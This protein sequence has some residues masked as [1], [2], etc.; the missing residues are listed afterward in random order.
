MGVFRAISNVLRSDRPA[1]V[2]M[3]VFAVIYALI[4][5]VNH[6]FFKTFALD[7]GVYTN[8]LYDYG[9]LHWNDKG[10]FKPVAENLLSDHLDFYLM[11]LAP[12]GF[13]F[14]QYTLQL[15]QIVFILFGSYGMYK[16]VQYKTD[17]T[18]MAFW[19][20]LS[21]LLSFAVFASLSFDYH[22]N[23]LAC[24]F[25]P[26]LFLAAEKN[27]LKTFVAL[28]IVI[29]LAKESMPLLMFFVCLGMGIELR[30]NK[31]IRNIA[32]VMAG[33]CLLYF[34][35][36]MKVIMPALANS[37]SYEHFKYHVLGNGYGDIPKFV[38]TRP[39][40]FLKALFINHSGKA[41]FDFIKAETYAFLL[42]S[43]AWLMIW[44]PAFLI[45]T[46][47]LLVMKMCYDDPAIW[48]IDTHYS[49]EFAPLIVTGA[50]YVLADMKGELLKQILAVFVVVGSLTATL[51]YMDN[52][53]YWHD[54]SRVR[55]YQASHY[56]KNYDVRVVHRQLEAIP[57]D[58]VVSAQ[59]PFVPHL[60]YRDKC[61]TFPI[62]K[63]AEYI[64]VSPS[65]EAMYPII[66]E[67]MD[68][69]IGDSLRTGR[70]GVQWRDT[71]VVVLRN[72]SGH[73]KPEK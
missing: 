28:V 26:W 24:M 25:L 6:Y 2:L 50:F 18:L 53:V 52:T 54:Y 67:E 59:T 23:V 11:A 12:L 60:A 10:V 64:I 41:E 57:A 15:F 47:P 37:G 36:A 31:R 39:L 72:L 49:I 27:R 30:Q 56:V 62:V 20:Q 16:L 63:D 8:T 22:S 55:I 51:R 1:F 5:F 48:S 7:L 65:E 73:R 66:R 61:Y 19:A 38:L 46:L 44:R 32:F 70:W 13:V 40:E 71:N 68:K 29:C 14:G 3:A 42:V 43:G 9:H 69:Q 4:A 17:S 35:L 21:L 33:L 58:A 34:L 45:M